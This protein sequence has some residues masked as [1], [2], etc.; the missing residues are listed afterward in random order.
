MFHNSSFWNSLIVKLFL[1]ICFILVPLIVILI[2][3]S[4]Y[5]VDVI[6]NQVAQSNKKMLNLHKNEI[7]KQLKSIGDFVYQL[8]NQ[9]DLLLLQENKD[10]EYNDYVEAK[11]RLYRLI[12]NQAN[13]SH[14]VDSLFIHAPYYDDMIYTQKFGN[15]YTERLEIS[16]EIKQLLNKESGRIPNGKWKLWQ[17]KHKNYLLYIIQNEDISVGA[18]IHVDK[19]ITPFKHINYGELGRTILTTSDFS[20]INHTKFLQ[21]EGI[22]LEDKLHPYLIKGKNDRFIVLSEPSSYADFNIVALIP[23]QVILQELPFIQRISI[24]ISIGSILLLILFVVLMRNIILTP[25]LQIVRAMKKLRKGDL[26]VRLPKTKSSTEFEMMNDSFNRMISDIHH[27]KIDGYE[28]KINL[29]KSELK[30]LQLQINP[31]F[32]LNSLNIIYNLATLKDFA[33]IQ[34]MSQSLSNYFRFMFKSN[35]YFV[36]LED[37]M[38]HTLNYLKIQELRFPHAFT[39]HV[40]IHPKWYRVKV[41]PLIIQS[42]VENTIKYGLNLD[43]SIKIMIKVWQREPE[44][45]YI[46]IQISDTGEGFSDEVLSL[47]NK[48]KSYI[49]EDGDRVGI[50]NIRRRLELLYEKNKASIDFENQIGAT[51]TIKLPLNPR[52]LDSVKNHMKN[53]MQD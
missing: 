29:Q 25:V 47:L 43:D 12:S 10:T 24:Y 39:Y 13:F 30:H 22:K 16:N 46:I 41:P 14:P 35:S 42:L 18:W 49:T 37:E 44:D 7:E 23:E 31:H 8:S 45:D 28:Q 4:F 27:L 53:T 26:K 11:L 50:W 2:I 19:L 9:A 38:K 17:G 48:D 20:P 40:D 33:L 34:Q 5:S 15:S 3:N 1:S 6:R 51:I 21:T 32:F 36:G 52:D